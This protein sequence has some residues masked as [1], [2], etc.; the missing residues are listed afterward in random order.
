MTSKPPNLVERAAAELLKSGNLDNSVA[1]LLKRDTVALPSTEP[2]V[3]TPMPSSE[4]LALSAAA[5]PASPAFGASDLEVPPETA[6]VSGRDNRT[7]DKTIDLTTLERAGIID[8][9]QARSR[10]S[11]EFRIIQRQVLRNTT[12]P[13]ILAQGNANLVMLTSA[14]PGE[15]KSFV[16]LNLAAGIARQRDHDVLLVDIDYKHN[17]IG[18]ALGLNGGRG[19]LDLVTDPSL[20]PG[21][22][23]IKTDIKNLSIL[24]IGRHAERSPELFSSRQATR[25]IQSLGRRYA[26]RLVILDAPPCLATSEPGVLASVVGQII[27]VVEAEKTQRN[28]VEAAMDILH[29]CPTITLLLNKVQVSNRFSFGTYASSYAQP[30]TS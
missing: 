10:I 28:E 16:S 6:I 2:G 3:A 1:Q 29:S 15:G 19:L 24:P 5:K 21:D 11:E 14:R 13:E 18:A 30:Y 22:L 20:D 17:S 27:M 25:L 26:D 7:P 9:G 12:L 23:I 8:W 4:A